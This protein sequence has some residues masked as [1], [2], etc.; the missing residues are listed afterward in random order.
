VLP[1]SGDSFG[2]AEIVVPDGADFSFYPSWSPDGKW[3]VFASAPGGQALISYNQ[4]QARLRLVARSGGPVYELARATQGV[5]NTSTLPKVAPFSQAGG[6]L[7]FVTFNSKIDYGF[8]LQN[9]LA[10]TEP[11]RT[12]QLWLA[13]IDLGK[14]A[15]D[16]DPSFAPVWLPFQ[17]T[18]QN[19]HLGFWTQG[20][21]CQ[22]DAGG[23]S[24]GCDQGQ[25]CQQGMC[26]WIVP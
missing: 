1:F 12:P 24:L 25:L 20:V 15:T 6:S 14:L 2:P 9:S 22:L 5:G 7:L 4:K 21:G 18:K 3:L 8:L 13:A 26:N 23:A 10:P 17:D 16:P 11:A 19:N